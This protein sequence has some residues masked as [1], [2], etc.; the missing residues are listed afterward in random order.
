MNLRRRRKRTTIRLFLIYWSTRLFY[1]PPEYRP[2]RHA[3]T[4]VPSAVDCSC[5]WRKKLT[6]RTLLR[7]RSAG[8]RPRRRQRPR[9]S[10][11]R[12]RALVV[13][14]R[15]GRDPIWASCSRRLLRLRWPF[16]RLGATTFVVACRRR[17]FC[18]GSKKEK[19]ESERASND[20]D[21]KKKNLRRSE[22]LLFEGAKRSDCIC[23]QRKE[24][25]K[26]PKK[27]SRGVLCAHEPTMLRSLSNDRVGRVSRIMSSL[28]LQYC[29]APLM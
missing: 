16:R 10:L 12:R 13:R 22:R 7:R 14:T 23:I 29:Y 5:C 25:E 6:R 19:Q 9:C 27:S 17:R 26:D 4:F 24:R 20:D 2:R 18:G 15:E 1:V 3:C 11:R 28:I 8:F 21:A